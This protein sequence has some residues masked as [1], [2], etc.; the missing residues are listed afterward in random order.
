MTLQAVGGSASL[1]DEA[2]SLPMTIPRGILLD[3][4]DTILDDSGH[5][6]NC[7]MDATATAE[8]IVPGLQA[9]SLRTAIQEYANWW[10]ADPERNRRGRL[11]L[12]RA[13]TGIV[14]E[15][16]RSLGFDNQAAASLIANRYRNLREERTELLDGA[17]ETLD[18]LRSQGIV[19]GL[20]TN[21]AGIPQRAK[22]E[23]FG[24][25]GYFQHIVIEGEFGV[26]KPDPKV[27]QTLL[28]ALGVGADEAWA[29]GDNL[30]VDVRGAMRLGLHGV[31]VDRRGRGALPGVQPDRI[32]GQLRDLMSAWG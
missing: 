31:W 9:D 16:L 13:T 17:L 10:W 27:F 2:P 30:E 11:D 6:E 20:M 22:I 4:D 21:G 28:T 7:W 29:I 26:G 18:W 25:A 14:E 15:V 32:I 23:R 19:L 5:A 24:L 1:T 12:R 8:N 3:L